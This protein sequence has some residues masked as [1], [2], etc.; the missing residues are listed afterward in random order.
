MTSSVVT[1]PIPDSTR[2]SRVPPA[3]RKRPRLPVRRQQSVSVAPHEI[4]LRSARHGV[5]ALLSSWG[6]VCKD[7]VD[8][9][10][11]IV[12]E[13]LT[14]ALLHTIPVPGDEIGLSVAEAGGAVLIEVED[15][16]GPTT[17]AIRPRAGDECEHGRGLALVDAMADSWAWRTLPNGRR[18]TWAYVSAAPGGGAW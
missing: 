12:S 7:V 9:V 13:L 16:G 18:S 4:A 5:T 11:L 10:E 6:L 14:N 1:S 2:S 8:T 15:G 3:L 17:P